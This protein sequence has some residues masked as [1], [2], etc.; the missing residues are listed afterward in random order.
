M[1]VNN[2][3]EW[4]FSE[5][6]AHALGA[7]S[8]NLV[9]SALA[10][11]LAFSIGRVRSPLVVVQ[12]Q[13]QVDKLLEVKDKLTQVRF[14]VYVDPTGM[15]SYEDNPWLISFA[16]LLERGERHMADQ[17]DYV[18]AEI[19]KGRPRD[20]AVM[21]QTSGTTGVPKIAMLSH[22]NL[23]AMAHQ[24]V[25]AAHIRPEENWISMSPT[26][27]IVDQMWGMGVALAGAMTMNFPETPETVLEDFRDIGPS[28]LI[29]ASRFWEDMAS[30]IRVKITD[31][32]WLKRK[33][34]YLGESV[35]REVVEKM[36]RKHFLAAGPLVPIPDARGL[37]SF[38]GAVWAVPVSAAPLPAAAISPDVIRFSGHRPE[39]GQCY[40]LTESCGIFNSTGRRGQLKR[41]QAASEHKH[42]TGRGSEVLVKSS[43]FFRILQRL[44]VHGGGV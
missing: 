30:R 27:W 44:P 37:Q 39:S 16:A 36:R 29:T 23:A 3:P 10:E 17:P 13:E 25:E 33:L 24:W 38:A 12:D 34:F 21:M 28:L 41:R 8:L 1:I 2:S 6:A 20:I 19:G 5:L 43:Q 32:G 15:T 9:T 14:V 18:D 35:G 40:G 42:Q 4:L 7:T 11:E 26:A 22:H 31:A